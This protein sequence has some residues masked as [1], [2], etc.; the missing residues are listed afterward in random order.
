MAL[1]TPSPLSIFLF[2]VGTV[3]TEEEE[4]GG[5]LLVAVTD[6]EEEATE[7]DTEEEGRGDLRPGTSPLECEVGGAAAV[8][9]AVAVAGDGVG[10]LFDGS[11][12]S[13]IFAN[14]F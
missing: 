8:V 7:E 2:F 12:M 5:G 14:C 4:G 3:L 13:F 11:E 6:K 9:V 10:L 1:G